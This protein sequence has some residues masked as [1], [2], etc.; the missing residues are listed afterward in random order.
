MLSSSWLAS[1]EKVEIVCESY[2]HHCRGL[3]SWKIRQDTTPK[4]SLLSQSNSQLSCVKCFSLI[5]LSEGE[6][7]EI[8]RIK[9]QAGSIRGSAIHQELARRIEQC[10]RA[11]VTGHLMNWLEAG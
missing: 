11:T 2:C 7:Q 1:A 6:H 8:N 5:D 9:Q 10:Q 3:N 4:T